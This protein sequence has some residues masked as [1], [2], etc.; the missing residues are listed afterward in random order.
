MDQHRVSPRT[1]LHIAFKDGGNHARV[2]IEDD[3]ITGILLM[4]SILECYAAG[5][6]V[7]K[8]AACDTMISDF[9]SMQESENHLQ[10]ARLF[11]EHKIKSLLIT[12][13]NGKFL[14]HMTAPDVIETLPASLV[15]N[16][17]PVRRIMIQNPIY[18]SESTSLQEAT[19]KWQLNRISCLIVCDNEQHVVGILS[20]SDVLRWI[21]NGHKNSTL[22][23]YMTAP[24]ITLSDK[25]SIRETWLHMQQHKVMKIAL[26]NEQGKL[27][28]LITATDILVAL[29]Q[30]VLDTFACY[31]CADQGDLMLEWRKGGMIMAVSDTLLTCFGM[32]HE[33]CVGLCWQNGCSQEVESKLLRLGKGEEM[34]V[35]WE[36]DGAALAFIATRDREQAIMWWKLQ[37]PW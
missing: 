34:H 27:T 5:Y 20:E 17:Q 7:K 13:R 14:R 8:L 16:F 11:A 18:I 36:V 23:D 9:I 37:L 29:C 2:V 15:I 6:D 28:G 24:V 19:E 1:P 22:Q 26:T 10:V 12:D 3:S 25:S 21:L 33:E 30:S 4:S 35:L 31:R 32:K